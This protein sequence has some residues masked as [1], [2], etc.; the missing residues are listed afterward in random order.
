MFIR[1]RVSFIGLMSLIRISIILTF[2]CAIRLLLVIIISPII[3]I[4]I[5]II[6]PARH[7]VVAEALGCGPLLRRNPRRP[8]VHHRRLRLREGM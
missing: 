6:S 8:C 1:I 7:R 4:V 5:I 3:I 2:I